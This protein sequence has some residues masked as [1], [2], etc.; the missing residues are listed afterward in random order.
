MNELRNDSDVNVYKEIKGKQPYEPPRLTVHGNL[1]RVT[2][3]GGT[4]HDH[5]TSRRAA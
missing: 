2:G 3:R 5:G 4:K 1:K